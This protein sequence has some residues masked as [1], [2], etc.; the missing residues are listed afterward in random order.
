MLKDFTLAAVSKCVSGDNIDG[1][2]NLVVFAA[3]LVASLRDKASDM[4]LSDATNVFL[5]TIRRELTGQSQ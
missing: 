4:G 5:D 1:R 3:E 2:Y